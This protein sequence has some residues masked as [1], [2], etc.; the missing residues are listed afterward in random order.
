MFYFNF[1]VVIEL[2]L[3]VIDV[4]FF[5]ITCACNRVMCVMRWHCYWFNDEDV[6]NCDRMLFDLICIVIFVLDTC[7]FN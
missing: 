4:V 2:Y 5:I 6:V 7:L 3:V 1:D